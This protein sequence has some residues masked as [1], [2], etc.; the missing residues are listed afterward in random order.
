MVLILLSAHTN[1]NF[2]I[3]AIHQEDD[4]LANNSKSSFGSPKP[5][6]Q[7]KVCYYSKCCSIVFESIYISK[8]N[9]CGVVEIFLY[10]SREV[11]KS[12]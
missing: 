9:I 2:S 7:P 8:F 6:R 3:Q 10:R 12:V 1:L 5:Q 11:R 4:K